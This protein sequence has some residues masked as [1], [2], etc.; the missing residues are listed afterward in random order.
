MF[1]FQHIEFLAGLLLVPFLLVLFFLLLRWKK[2]RVKKIGDERLVKELVK[3]FSPFKFTLRFILFLLALMLVVIGAAN[4]QKPGGMEKVDRK[5]VDVMIAMDVSKSMLAEDI[6]PNRLERAKQLVSKLMDKMEND[7]VGLVLF[8]GRAYMQMP[9]TTDHSAA[10]MYIQNAGPNTVP[11]QGT[12][13]AEALKMANSSFNSKDRKYKSILLISDGEDHDA[14]ALKYTQALAANGVM[15]NTVGIGSPNGVP[16]IDPAT[17]ELRKDAQGNAIVTRL[18]EEELQQL[19]QQTKG[20]YVRLDDTDDAV[21][22]IMAQ[23]KTIE[24]T[25]P[26][27][28][29]FMSYKS[30]FQWF[31][32]AALVLLLIELF[33]SERKKVQL[34]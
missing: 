34:V 23:L 1:H 33:T 28:Q 24:Q 29:A 9:L 12:V 30:Y 3:S 18:N 11:T 2:E 14:E 15:V 13:I 32:A 22:R 20:V 27:D 17:N 21:G 5:G 6:Q 4:L 26:G 7:R 16:L 19:A 25:S 8:A 31:L 10:R